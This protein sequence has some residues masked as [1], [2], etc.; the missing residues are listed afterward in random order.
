MHA[1]IGWVNRFSAIAKQKFTEL[2]HAFI[3]EV[4]G[5]A[6]DIWFDFGHG[7]EDVYDCLLSVQAIHRQVCL[8]ASVYVCCRACVYGV[9]CVC[10]CARVY[11]REFSTESCIHVSCVCV[12]V[13]VYIHVKVA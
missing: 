8:C 1:C 2:D 9:D 12:C 5:Q 11:V 4:M 3:N 6:H 13:Y 7:G 10:S